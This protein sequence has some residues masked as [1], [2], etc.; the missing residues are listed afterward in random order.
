M[1]GS[2]SQKMLDML[3]PVA[4]AL[5][6]ELLPYV[7]FVGGDTTALL[8]TDPITLH[9]IRFTEDV[10]LIVSVN[11]RAHWMRLQKQ[12]RERGFKESMQDDLTCRMRLGELK[13]DFMH[14]DASILGFTNRWYHKALANTVAYPLSESIT[15]NLLTPAY[16][17][18]TK[19][20]AYH[21]RGNDDPLSSHDLEDIINLVDGRSELM[22]EIAVADEDVRSYIAEQFGTLQA[23]PDFEY[24]VQGNLQDSG[25]SELFF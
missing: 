8:V 16:F 19:L 17:I 23:H 25:R 3:L 14:D 11:G 20:E 21:G 7:A 1:P 9:A 4:E 6:E 10:D 18:A 15:I 5:G 13:V 22:A 12:L 2:I 24:A